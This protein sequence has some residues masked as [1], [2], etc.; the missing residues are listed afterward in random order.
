MVLLA[1]PALAQ[2]SQ[3]ERLAEQTRALQRQPNDRD[4]QRGYIFVLEDAGSPQLALRYATQHPGLLDA[5]EQRRIESKVAAQMIRQGQADNAAEI[6]PFAMTD[7][8][9]EMLNRHIAEWK[10]L[11]E[12]AKPEWQRARFDRMVA[13]YD[14]ARTKEVVAEYEQLRREKIEVPDYALGVVAGSYLDQRQ[15]ARARTIYETL[16]AHDPA[17]REAKEGLFYAAVKSEDFDTAYRIADGLANDPQATRSDRAGGE[18]LAA[19]AR[20]YGDELPEA[21]QRVQALV[22]REPRDE[23]YRMALASVYQA[24]GMPRA[25]RGQNR[26]ALE[27]SGLP[28]RELEVQR[29]GLDLNLQEFA[30]ARAAT[31]DLAARYPHHRS[32]QRAKRD[33]ALHDMAV[34]R[35]DASKAFRS[36]TNVAGGEGYGVD[37]TLYSPPIRE[38]WRVFGGQFFGQQENPGEEG[39]ILLS[40]SVVG[41]EYRHRGIT[42][43]AAPTFSHYDDS[44]NRVGAFADLAYRANDA[45][46]V[47]AGGEIFSRDTPLRA[48][49]D[50]VTADA[51]SAFARWRHGE[52][53]ALRLGVG[54][55]PFSDGNDRTLASADYSRMLYMVP[56]WR[57]NGLVGIGASTNSADQNRLYYNPDTDLLATAGFDATQIL[58]REYD[59][60]FRH[61]LQFVAGP[62]WQKDYGTSAAARALYTQT[63]QP[64]DAFEMGWGANWSHQ[65]YDG[66]PENNFSLLLNLTR[67]F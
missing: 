12:A 44:N 32:V 35:I 14:R 5:A 63:L 20:L 54:F 9:I 22:K 41:L 8:A 51:V 50:G 34:L 15:P 58:Y 62:Y 37:A 11:G 47:G 46:D 23:G 21:E 6:E 52:A 40:R 60:V 45:W 18:M 1:G 48:L 17:N 39:T 4:T 19:R 57:V 16:L 55:M 24:R 7:R 61:A 29:A 64:N 67:R 2:P 42:A 38:N 10:K 43:S 66:T 53:Q 27:L 28:Q 56:H 49:N 25:A 59:Y 3:A 65:A 31:T 26:T 36:D 13:W 30:S 33:L